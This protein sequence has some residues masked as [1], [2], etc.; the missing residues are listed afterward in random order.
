MQIVKGDRDRQL[1][2]NEGSHLRKMKFQGYMTRK[3]HNGHQFCA[4][5]R[6]GGGLGIPWSVDTSGFSNWF[7]THTMKRKSL[8]KRERP[9]AKCQGYAQGRLK[10][11]VGPRQNFLDPFIRDQKF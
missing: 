5:L 11:I 2:N 6:W 8:R 7:A 10:P 1:S 3:L 9:R 4:V